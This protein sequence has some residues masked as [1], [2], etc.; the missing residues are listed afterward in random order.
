VPRPGYRAA[1][2]RGV[3]GIHYDGL[4][5]EGIRQVLAA[6]NRLLQEVLAQLAATS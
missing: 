6:S 2:R 3:G 5:P 4:S 1:P